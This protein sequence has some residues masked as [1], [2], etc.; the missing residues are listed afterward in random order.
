MRVIIETHQYFRTMTTLA[1]IGVS[2]QLYFTPDQAAATDECGPILG[3]PYVVTCGPGNYTRGANLNTITYTSA[4]FGELIVNVQSGTTITGDAFGRA[5]GNKEIGH[6]LFISNPLGSSLVVNLDKD[7]TI[8]TEGT[9]ANGV[10]ARANGDVTVISSARISVAAESTI[11]PADYGTGTAGIYAWNQASPGNVYIRQNAYS[12]IPGNIVNSLITAQGYESGGLYALNEGSGDAIIDVNGNITITDGYNSFGANAYVAHTFT[13][14]AIVRQGSNSVINI[15]GRRR[16]AGIYA[17]NIST[18]ETYASV[19]GKINVSGFESSGASSVSFGG[20]DAK[21]VV[22]ESGHIEV[23]GLGANGAMTY[24]GAGGNAHAEISGTIDVRGENGSGIRAQVIDPATNV[25]SSTYVTIKATGRISGGWKSGTVMNTIGGNPYWV[26]GSGIEVMSGATGTSVIDNA[27]TIGALSDR[28]IIDLGRLP[29]HASNGNLTLNNTGTITGYLELADGGS[30][31]INNKA[32]STH[33]VRHFEDRDGDGL[34]DT[35]AVAISDFGEDTSRYNNESGATVRLGAVTG[36]AATDTSNYYNVTAGQAQTPL[37]PSFYN[38]TRDGLVQGQFVNLGLF[39]NHG[40]IDLTGS[41]I[42]N[43]LVMTTNATAGG[44]AGT[45]IFRSNGGNLRLNAILNEGQEVGGANGSYADTLTVDQTELGAGGPTTISVAR[46]EGIGAQ[47]IGNGILLVE[48]RNKAASAPGVFTLNGD[49]VEN[50]EQLLAHG[51]YTYNLNHNGLG[52]DATDSNWYL[53]NFGLVPTIPSYQDYPKILT[54]VIRPPTLRQ[55][56]GNHQWFELPLTDPADFETVYCKDATKNFRCALTRE[57]AKYYTSADD[58]LVIGSNG[59]WGRMTGLHGDYQSPRSTFSSTT[60]LN[61]FG[62]Q[63]GY[64]FLIHENEAGQLI[65]GVNTAYSHYRAKTTSN[66]M[67]GDAYSLGTSLTWYDKNGFYLDGQAA[68]HGIWTDFDSNLLGALKRDHRAIGYTASLEVGQ[69]FAI[70]DKLALVPQAQ[71]SYSS[72]NFK[73]FTD[74]Y[75]LTI[76]LIDGESLRGRL[77]LAAEYDD[78]WTS[79]TSGKNRVKA[80]GIV[81]IYN[82]F[83]DG[84]SVSLNGKSFSARPEKLWGGIGFG[85]Q[86]SWNDDRYAVHAEV[87]ANTSLKEFGDSYD[88]QGNIGFKVRW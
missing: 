56:V 48:V 45:G 75:L 3:P 74:P 65:G 23:K 11:D 19:A 31:V 30:N 17:L 22:E 88:I 1:I 61:Q 42:G 77:G 25:N 81:N 87:A 50:G 39:D 43:S 26:T 2:V 37:D 47:T 73:S 82:E 76:N 72:V 70:S 46:R 83:L 55:R 21:V 71:L 57:Q 32:G 13:G 5:P 8:N 36:N 29:E 40:T 60:N 80:Y 85:G 33:I 84:T 52:T 66:T 86:Y 34:R 7:V 6:G 51:L 53:R 28:A 12:D 44:A 41:A 24:V 35:K 9:L 64:D 27:G 62:I 49:F 10:Y 16:D 68:L 78:S 20:S 15:E 63:A 54:E 18:G 58:G 38:L 79:Q 14:D 67:T 4:A 69:R 59:I